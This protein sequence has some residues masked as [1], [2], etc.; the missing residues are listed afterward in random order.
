MSSSAIWEAAYKNG[1]AL[2]LLVRKVTAEKVLDRVRAR[3]A[4]TST[5]ST[6]RLVCNLIGAGPEQPDH[7]RDEDR[8]RRPKG[9]R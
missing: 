7:P 1:S 9:T 6:W 3:E 5:S 8:P 2:F 4:E